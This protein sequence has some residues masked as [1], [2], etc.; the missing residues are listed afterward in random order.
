MKLII[1]EYLGSLIERDELDAVLPDLLS[2]LGFTVYSR[3]QRGT[4]QHGVDIAAV[5][6]DE[7][8]ERKVFL[9][10]VKQGDLTRQDWDGTPQS[11]RPSLNE[12]RDAYIPSRIPKRYSALK[13]VICLCFGGDVQEQ[14][15][16]SI[17]GYINENTTD[18]I[19]FDEWNGDRIASLLLS[20]VLRENIFP[21]HM[22]SSF[23]KA[24]AMVDEPDVAYRH[25]VD[26]MFKLR[27]AADTSQKASVRAARQIYIC[28]WILFVWAR[29]I[30]NIEAPY[31]TS[32][33][34]L[35]NIWHLFRPLIGKKSKNAKA[36][37]VVVDQLIQLHLAI[38]GEFLEKKVFPFVDKQHALSMAVQSQSHVDINL[39]L[40]DLLGR[41]A[42]EGLWLHWLLDIGEGKAV[43]ETQEA[44]E[45]ITTNGFK[46]IQNNPALF[47]PL[48]DQHAIEI[49]LFLMLSVISGNNNEN[50]S[51]WLREIVDRLSITVPTHGRYPCVFTDYRDLIDHPRER[52]EE[53]RTEATSGSMLLPLLASWLIALKDKGALAKLIELTD[54]ELAHCTLQLWLADSASEDQMYRG[55]HNHG[56]ALTDL[57]LSATGEEL[58]DTVWEA[59]RKEKGFEALSAI[60]CGF[61]PIITLA[62]RHFRHPLPPQF[63]IN[64]VRTTDIS[65]AEVD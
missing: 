44:I 34:A 14:V 18:H 2:E 58:L 11:L 62:C 33:L 30:D 17:T 3:P 24:V 47:S 51:C 55:G 1:R 38:A 37:G 64:L 56:V 63:W 29:D 31:R 20:G 6:E 45:Q 9:F 19:S 52:S 8:G 61:W 15:R 46:L 5:G 53:Y 36:V 28:L 35:L 48:C 12:I 60:Q 21:K 32:E 4:V 39:K 25:F 40:F 43:K 16:A 49:S 7:D 50:I 65:D 26:L 57:R 59:C 54:K 41:V 27:K 23:Q 10:S 13:V 22:R 42:M